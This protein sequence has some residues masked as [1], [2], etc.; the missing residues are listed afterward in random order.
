MRMFSRSSSRERGSGEVGVGGSGEVGVGGRGG[1]D[2]GSWVVGEGEVEM[3]PVS[4][5]GGER[6]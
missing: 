1:E 4:L 2:G 5:D 6:E 3:K